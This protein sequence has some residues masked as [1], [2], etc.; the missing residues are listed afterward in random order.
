MVGQPELRTTLSLPCLL[1]LRQRISINCH[2]APLSRPEVEEYILHRLEIAGNREAVTFCPDSMD[3]IYRYSR[4]IPRLVN[5]I[6]DFLMLSAFA[7]ETREIDEDMVRDVIGDLD[8]E[9]QFWESGLPDES[10]T[11]KSRD[12][13]SATVGKPGGVMELLSDIAER[14]SKLEK[15]SIEFRETSLKEMGDHL[16]SLGSAFRF[17]A[18]ETDA[19]VSELKELVEKKT[20]KGEASF[21]AEEDIAQSLTG[22]Q[23]LLAALKEKKLKKV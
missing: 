14:L 16:M 20:G 18:R 12:G 11:F 13:I 17:Y 8:F 3:I 23:V 15:E 10:E 21:P 6:C 7:E 2:L 1:Q 4:G 5:I 9:N 19:V 22:Q